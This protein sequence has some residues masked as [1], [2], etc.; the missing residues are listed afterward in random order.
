MG[1]LFSKFSITSFSLTTC[2][3]GQGLEVTPEYRSTSRSSRTSD[4]PTFR[5]L[6]RMLRRKLAARKTIKLVQVTIFLHTATVYVFLRF[7]S[8]SVIP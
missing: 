2:N 5:L 1:L 6:L 4:P 7:E 8:V 3:V